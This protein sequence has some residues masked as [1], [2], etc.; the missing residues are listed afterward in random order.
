M[1]QK[2]DGMTVM[3]PG[4]QATLINELSRLTGKPESDLLASMIDLA[5]AYILAELHIGRGAAK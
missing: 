2:L 4:K 1:S 3:L 5:A